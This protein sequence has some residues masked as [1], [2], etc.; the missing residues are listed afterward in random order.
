MA[1]FYLTRIDDVSFEIQTNDDDSIYMRVYSQ[2]EGEFV[3]FNTDENGLK[4][5]RDF[6]DDYFKE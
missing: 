6:L 2:N 3:G 4:Q 1:Q 5:L